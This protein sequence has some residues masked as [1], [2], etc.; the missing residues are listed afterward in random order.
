LDTGIQV[1]IEDGDIHIGVDI[2]V[3]EEEEDGHLIHSSGYGDGLDDR[4]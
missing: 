1:D 2:L 3:I 4:Q